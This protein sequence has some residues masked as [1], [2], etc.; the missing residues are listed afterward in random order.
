MD[1]RGAPLTELIQACLD[2]GDEGAWTEFV[3]R[4]HRVI[5]STVVKSCRQ[6]GVTM[7]ETVDDLIQET[8]AKI[9]SN[10]CRILR[11]FQSPHPDSA[12]GLFKATAY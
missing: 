3:G 10:E 9:C 2:S 7:P 12:Y 4:F 5:A 8:Y 11:D 1:F 6:H